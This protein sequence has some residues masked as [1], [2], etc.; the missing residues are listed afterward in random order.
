[1][2]C[3]LVAFVITTCVSPGLSSEGATVAITWTRPVPRW[4]TGARFVAVD[5]GTVA[6]AYLVVF[7]VGVAAFQLIRSLVVIVPDD[8]AA[9]AIGLGA[10][11]CVMWYGLILLTSARFPGR[12]GMIA[13]LSWVV[14]LVLT[15]IYH[16]PLPWLFH[17]LIV[18]LNYLNP[19]AYF[20]S[21]F[22]NGDQSRNIIALGS[23]GRVVV[24]WCIGIAATVAGIRLWSTREA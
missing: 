11:V 15:G 22:S 24:P 9:Y 21:A 2:A 19:L 14:F 23:T 20:G 13:G 10:G 17:D 8:D 4:T 6:L 16:A 5:L 3:A 12:G 7:V 18:G 1:M